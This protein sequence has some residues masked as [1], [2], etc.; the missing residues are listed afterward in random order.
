M[1][2]SLNRQASNVYLW[3]EAVGASSTCLFAGQVVWAQGALT[4]RRVGCKSSVSKSSCPH[5][6]TLESTRWLSP[7]CAATVASLAHPE[8]THTHRT[9]TPARVNKTFSKS[10]STR[11]RSYL[12]WVQQWTKEVGCSHGTADEHVGPWPKVLVHATHHNASKPHNPQ[13]GCLQEEDLRP[14]L[15]RILR[16]PSWWVW[17]CV[18]VVECESEIDRWRRCAIGWYVGSVPSF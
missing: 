1:G 8:H 6:S 3:W 7:T 18:G 15:A 5:N 17:G 10:C 12:V 11:A 9:A 4:L 14:A 2:T 13:H 16:Q